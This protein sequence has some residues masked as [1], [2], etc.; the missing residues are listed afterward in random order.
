MPYIAGMTLEDDGIT[1]RGLWGIAWALAVLAGIAWFTAASL[2]DEPHPITR[3][4]G[5]WLG[6]AVVSTVFS[7]A[8][9]V[10]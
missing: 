2:M 4:L 6:T 7:G 9:A 10:L 3:S 5:L 1:A 8:C